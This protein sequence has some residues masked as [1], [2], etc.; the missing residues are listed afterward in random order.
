MDKKEK[1]KRVLDLLDILKT[2]N[3]QIRGRWESLSPVF[4]VGG[5]FSV[6][7]PFFIE[8]VEAVEDEDKLWLNVQ[9]LK[10]SFG[11]LPDGETPVVGILSGVFKNE[12][13]IRK[14][15]GAVSVVD[16]FNKFKNQVREYYGVSEV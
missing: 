10:E 14:T 13:E 16:A 8:G 7:H 2:L 5:V 3:R 11:Y 15:L 4:V 9:R 6:K 12:E 1:A